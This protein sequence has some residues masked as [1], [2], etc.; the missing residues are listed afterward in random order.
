MAIKKLLLVG[1]SGQIGLK[2]IDSLKSKFNLYV[3]D[4]KILNIKE[5]KFI[6]KNCLNNNDLKKL[7][8]NFDATIFL[9]GKKGGPKSLNINYYKDYFKSNCE[10]LINFLHS[11]RIN[12]QKKIIFFSTEH[13]YGDNTVVGNKKFEE[14]NPK[15]FYGSTKLLSEK[16]L[17]NFW[18]NNKISVDILR[19]P[20]IIIDEKNII[21]DI[22]VKIKKEKI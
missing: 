20:R 17:Y 12:F 9:I 15:N 8:K 5:I 4:N 2:I 6:K 11:K 16:I 21:S 18:D 14:P 10:T 7:P 19:V 1:G 13:V 22:F 3:F